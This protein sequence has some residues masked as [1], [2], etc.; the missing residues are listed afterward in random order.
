MHLVLLV[1][2]V[3]QAQLVPLVPWERLEP[4]D[5]QVLKVLP[6]RLVLLELP[7]PLDLPAHKV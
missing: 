6:A 7:E 1:R 3:S 2:R 4:L 5:L